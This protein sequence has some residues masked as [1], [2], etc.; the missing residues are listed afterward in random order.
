MEFFRIENVN[1]N[2]SGFQALTDVSLSIDQGQVFGLLGPNGAGKTT[3]IRIINQIT[4]PD[5]GAVYFEGKLLGANDIYRIG[6][7]PE[8]RGLYKKMKVGEQALYLAQLKGLDR[9]TALK[10]LK[11]WFQ[12]F[13]IESWWDKKLQELSKGM[14]QKVQF[15]CTVLHEPKLLIFD[16]PFSG[17][18]PINAN[19]LKQ[20]I[21]SLRDKGAT[22][23]FSTHNMS[24]VE[25]ICD[26]IALINKS[27][28]ILDGNI[29]EVR[30]SFKTNTFDV[31]YR[32]EFATVEKQLNH[33]FEILSHKEDDWINSLTIKHSGGNNNELLQLI[34]P[35][36]EI[37]SFSERIPSMNEVFIRVV[38]NNK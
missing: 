32:G 31:V 18:D 26:H 9:R 6:Y 30:A 17:F 13:E 14:Q 8:E 21:L 1:K 11:F 29:N 3:L 5:S 15:I 20:E 34:T 35:H 28:K 16:E 19:L 12:K 25:E 36:V 2:Y 7:L 33:G 23:I 22:I 27:K 24:S 4:A 38:E 10:R 37:V